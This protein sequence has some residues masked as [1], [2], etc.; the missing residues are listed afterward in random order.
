MICSESYTMWRNVVSRKALQPAYG[1][2]SAC[3][4]CIQVQLEP[5]V[6][7]GMLSV[8]VVCCIMRAHLRAPCCRP[9]LHAWKLRTSMELLHPA[10]CTC[11][12]GMVAGLTE[13]RELGLQKGYEI[14]VWALGQH[15]SRIFPLRSA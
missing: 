1:A 15:S 13:G 3:T 5:G 8:H 10:W 14:G 2:T 4:N 9:A 12:D 6:A 7:L 11:R